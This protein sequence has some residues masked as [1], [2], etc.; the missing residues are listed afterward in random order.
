MKAKMSFLVTRPAYPVPATCVMSIL[1]SAA[2][3]RT[4]GV[5]RVRSRSSSVCSP[6]S[7]PS[8][9]VGAAGEG[10]GAGTA[11]APAGATAAGAGVEGG[12]EAGALSGAFSAATVSPACAA[13]T[14]VSITAITV[15]T[16]TVSPS[17]TLIS[18]ST[19]P[20]GAGISAST[21]SVEISRIASS[22]LTSS[23]TCF[24]HFETVPSA[25]DSPICGMMTSTLDM[26]LLSSYPPTGGGRSINRLSVQR[27]V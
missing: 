2:I 20:A 23:P 1:C 5:E 13:V 26:Q 16:S 10:D 27:F 25:I 11:S 24:S 6:P 18:A 7:R 12:T 8:V 15:C 4:S 14:S 19:P 21:L 17:G 9:A 3:F 22:R